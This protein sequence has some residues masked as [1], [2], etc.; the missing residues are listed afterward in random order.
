MVV[1][2][3][4]ACLQVNHIDVAVGPLTQDVERPGVAF[5]QVED[6]L[7]GGDD[8]DTTGGNPV[9]EVDEVGRASGAA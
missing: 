1:V 3:P 2:R 4:T 6:L 8:V 7:L 5:G 9:V